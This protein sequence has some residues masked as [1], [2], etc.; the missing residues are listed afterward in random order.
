VDVEADRKVPVA[1]NN[2]VVRSAVMMA[3]VA[4][5]AREEVR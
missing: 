5:A 2:L 1:A 3:S 4:S